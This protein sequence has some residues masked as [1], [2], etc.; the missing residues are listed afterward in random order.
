MAD[1]SAGVCVAT[2]ISVTVA[3]PLGLDESDQMV[4]DL[5][6]ATGVSWQVRPVDRRP[7]L[8]VDFAE[9]VL[10]AVVGKG[11]EMTVEAIG[12]AV[13]ETVKRWRSER[14]DPPEIVIDEATTP[15]ADP[16]DDPDA[17]D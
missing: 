5:T 15:D 7:T 3:G 2:T 1:A 10:T 6:R 4:T 17:G 9:I 16:T 8:A 11:M 14:L 13:R 12:H